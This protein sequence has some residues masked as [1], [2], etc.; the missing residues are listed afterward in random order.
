MPNHLCLTVTFL[1]PRF[2]GRRDGGEPEWPPSPLRLFQAIVA[3]AAAPTGRIDDSTAA[4]LRW[5][6]RLPPPRIVSPLA[7]LGEPYRLS[8]PNNAMD[9]VTSSWARG[10]YESKDAN[11]A[12]HRTMKAVRPM[13]LD[14]GDQVRYTWILPDP[15][16]EDDR[17]H[18]EAIRTAVQG[19]V[20]L[21][22]GVDLAVGH[23][24]LL[25]SEGVDYRDAK[26]S[27]QWESISNAGDVPLR[28]PRPGTFDAVVGRHH[29]FLG[30]VTDGGFEPVPPLTTFV[31]AS[32]RNTNMP[33][34]RP[35]AA[36][37]LLRPDGD[38]ERFA[39][40]PQYGAVHVAAMLRSAAC[41][42][43]KEDLEHSRPHLSEDKWRAKEAWGR[44]VVAGHGENEADKRRSRDDDSPR[45]SYLPLPSFELR[46][47][48]KSAVMGDIRR[49]VIA[50]FTGR[51]TADSIAW[52]RQRMNGELLIDE[53]TGEAVAMLAPLAEGD[54]VLQQYTGGYAR[55]EGSRIWSSVTPVILPGYDDGRPAKRERLLHAC[56]QQAGLL[57]AVESLESRP[58]SWFPGVASNAQFND[59]NAR[60]LFKRRPDYL[61]HLPA[62]HVR[63]RFREPIPGPLS[64]G[65][66]RHCGLGILAAAAE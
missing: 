30:R 18:A 19:I 7:R 21:G 59:L 1:D 10:T 15:L 26:G 37:K 24:E 64:L 25:L 49:V 57:A 5:F 52:V 23:G 3:A 38:A 12:T 60:G 17:R 62:V 44:R 11:P 16:L 35:F 56:L 32:Y 20:A 55:G 9:I 2:H 48:D 14:G 13:H 45:L 29:A 39:T 27:E 53:R 33:P 36:F 58:P 34:H 4:A 65:A 61:R 43:A 42:L 51:D 40:F 31:V 54:F 63:L 46:G 28:I 41:R 8:V 47:R 66:G 50:E 22:W 6:E